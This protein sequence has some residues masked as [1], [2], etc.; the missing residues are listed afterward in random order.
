M[1]EQGFPAIHAKFIEIA[2]RTFKIA[3]FESNFPENENHKFTIFS[4]K[5]IRW[6]KKEYNMLP[7]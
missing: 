5:S 2:Q 6:E 1:L 3:R 4:N 7:I